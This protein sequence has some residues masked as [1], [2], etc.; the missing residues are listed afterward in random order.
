MVQSTTSIPRT[1]CRS[2]RESIAVFSG[3]CADSSRGGFIP[4]LLDRDD[5]QSP[6]KE[7][8]EHEFV[9]QMGH[10]TLP[11][12]NF[13]YYMIQDYLFLVQF[14]RA[15]ALSAY[16]SSDLR[17]IG[18]S[19]Q[20]V[21]TLQEEI[22]LHINFC[23]EYG[24][25]EADIVNQE[26]DQGELSHEAR[27]DAA[28][29]ESATTAY[30]RYVLDIGQ[31]QDWLAL[32]VALLPCLIGYGII[33]RRLYEDPQTVRVGSR[34]WEWILQYVGQEYVDAM[35]R[36]SDLIEEHA[37]KQ[38]VSRVE[39]L[40]QIFIHAT[41]VSRVAR[42][43]GRLTFPELICRRWKGGFGIWGCGR[44]G[45]WLEFSDMLRRTRTRRSHRAVR[46]KAVADRWPM[47]GVSWWRRT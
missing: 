2:H 15:N 21:V 9:R 39:E 32:Q 5:I 33:A 26:E 17:D 44:V 34:Y 7:Y 40:A 1:P 12:E 28:D 31:S 36:G 27:R 13:K 46:T 41:N 23:K 16:K 8:T 10:G 42:R 35:M 30:T 3:F 29:R 6:W 47:M 4:Y 38:S 20:Q 19:V 14:A 43:L 25:E 24:L 22:Q 45:A 37:S 11:V 18:R